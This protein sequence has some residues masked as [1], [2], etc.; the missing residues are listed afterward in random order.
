MLPPFYQICFQQQLKKA[1]YLTLTILVFLLQIRKQVSIELLATLMPYPIMFESRRQFKLKGIQK[2][3]GRLIE[4]RR[5]QRRHS[6]FWIGLYGQLWV[7]GMEFC[8]A[9]IAELMKIRPNK[10]PFFQRG[11]KAMSFILSSF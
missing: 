10:L 9:T 1:E 7:V 5:S 6:S 2:Y 11:L 4:S 8:H 3:I